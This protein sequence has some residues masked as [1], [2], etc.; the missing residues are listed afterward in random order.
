[1]KNTFKRSAIATAVSIALAAASLAHAAPTGGTVIAGNATVTSSAGNTTIHQTSRNA[2]LNW[3]NFDIGAGESVQF[4]QPNGQSVALNR[5][6]GADATHILGSLSSN[7]KVFLI[8][9]NGVLFGKSAQVSVGGLVA[10]TANLSVDDFM[11][12]R[13]KLTGASSASIVNQGSIEAHDG[14]YVALLGANVSNQG[15]VVAKLG[16]VALASGSAFTLDMAGDGLLN[17]SVDAG[18]IG[19]LARNGGLIQADGGNV[20]LTAQGAGALLPSAVNNT[21]V[22]Q[23][24]TISE[25]NGTIKLLGDMGSGGV[26]AGGVLDASAPAGGNGGFIE[27]SAAHV[28]IGPDI[29]IT[30]AA[31]AGT[32]GRWL[33]DPVDYTI[34]ASG[35]DM[36]GTA[37]STALA[38]SNVT[39]QSTAGASGT[40]G[41]VN[42]ND[43]VAWSTNQLTLNAQRNI[44]VNAPMNGSGTASLAF[45]YGQ[46][47]VAAG[48]TALANVRAPVTLPSGSNF[49]TTLGSDGSVASY[50][51]ITNMTGLQAI[52]SSLS[53]NFALG[54]DLNASG[55]S[56]FVPIGNSS[57]RFGGTFNGLAHTISNLSINS[58]ND[59][60]GLFGYTDTTA[61]VTSLRMQNTSV[62]I[63]GRSNA[64]SLVGYNTGTIRDVYSDNVNVNAARQAGG[65]VGLNNGG[66][67]ERSAT[68]S[69]YVNATFFAG[70]LVAYL[71]SGTI[72]D[73]YSGVGAG[74]YLEVGGLIGGMDAGTV[75]NSY[76]YGYAS[77][78]NQ[79]YGP[80]GF[81]SYSVGGTISNGFWNQSVNGTGVYLGTATG[82]TGLDS[83]GMKTQS[84]FTNAGWDF[85][86]VWFMYAGSTMPLLRAFMT[87]L[88]VTSNNA[89]ATYSGSAYG[90]SP[91]VTYSMTPNM[92][93][94][95]GTLSY[96]S[97]GT[98]AG[99]SSLTPGGLYSNQLG[100]II[101][102]AA[103]TLTIN[104]Y[105]VSL[106]GSRPYDG[107]STVN[108]SDLTFG[109][110][111][112]GETLTLTGSGTV[113][114]KN[115]SNGKTVT[116]GTLALG[117]GTGQASNY[118]FSGGTQTISVT[119]KALAGIASATDKLY[120]ANTSASV[121]FSGLT[122]FVGSETVTATGSGTFNSK[123]VATANQ[124][125]VN[126]TAL[127][128]GTNGGL[129]SNYSLASGQT[130]TAHITP[131]A[132][133]TTATAANKVYDGNTTASVTLSG[134]TGLI[135][136]ETLGVTG[137]GAFNS[138]DVA[139]ANLVTVNSASLSN[140]TNGG[141]ASNY[142]LAS[143]ETAAAH[144]TPKALT[145]ASAIANEKV[146]DGNT[147][148]SVTL[149]G[150]TGLVG[151][152]TVGTNGSGTFN[153]KDVA[154]ANQV[155]VNG[156][157]LADGTNGGLGSNYSLA[158]G[159]TATAHITP[160]ALTATATATDKVYDGTITANVALSGLTGLVGSETL[161]ITSGGTFNS[162]DVATANLVTVNSASLSNGANGGLASNYSLAGGETATAHIT[163]KALTVAGQ[164]AADKIYD[165]TTAATL[166]HGALSG[167]VSDDSVALVQ[168]GSFTSANP[169]INIP[170]TAA[171]S[172]AGTAARNYTIIQPAGLH[173]S[174]D[175]TSTQSYNTAL[176]SAAA[177]VSPA[178]SASA[179]SASAG[180]PVASATGAGQTAST[181]SGNTSS[182][183]T[184][185][186]DVEGLNLTVITD[187]DSSL[188]KVTP[189]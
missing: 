128:D 40:A 43:T 38:A 10:S 30:T 29:K 189:H 36:T 16:T 103:G 169:G 178:S 97:G 1:M 172:L 130:A 95:L 105:A 71:V 161:G 33:I 84:N 164:V 49:S 110:L 58:S 75:E 99:T 92:S 62:Y 28:T 22:I 96:T 184:M 104:P 94:V 118:T 59:N 102:Y 151:N 83:A 148:A 47:A 152:E 173:A 60:G 120:D 139:T 9:P 108:A 171:D 55:F 13:Y 168:A 114:S 11:A 19:A 121:T 127:A 134:L 5:V 160:K 186:F 57:T 45:V 113:V 85:T 39:I 81:A 44:N 79:T 165:G 69:G 116:L 87:P 98:N 6:L 7:G 89:I 183:G 35:G 20:L 27:T 141:L 67:I 125:T 17:V 54:S 21:G 66:T 123:D 155:T 78:S 56:G 181:P 119:P 150:L 65:L 170:V 122:G 63:G 70:G 156:T 77:G 15:T 73:S 176:S 46:G 126:G 4:V 162:K 163:P 129:A 76:A 91:G 2:A 158:G 115:A 100:Y 188:L 146:Y 31:P 167:V 41:D 101:T 48:N 23:A 135:G 82:V 111:A 180:A 185:K 3:Q 147:S 157:T 50:T 8:N 153:S 51:V 26:V 42:V 131:K 124:V 37:L 145:A 72:R 24:Q 32:T 18:A 109:T 53:G 93:N 159:Q 34:A 112:N 52:G 12:G 175:V 166:S 86:N 142:S 74:S 149:S 138:K 179:G 132:L 107:T 182:T 117:D 177:I 64:G 140:G 90:G 80:G 88:T 187:D 154:T 68:P 133:T 106:T 137:S 14:G 136:G 25:H 61:L 174:I 143:G 144:I